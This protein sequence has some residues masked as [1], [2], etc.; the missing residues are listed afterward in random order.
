M[1]LIILFVVLSSVLSG[2]LQSEA[3][4]KRKCAPHAYRWHSRGVCDCVVG[5]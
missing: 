4:C 2:C 3:D 1:R 5:P